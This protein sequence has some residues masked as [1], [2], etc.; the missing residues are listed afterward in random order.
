MIKL[1]CINAKGSSRLHEG[2]VYT[3]AGPIHCCNDKLIVLEEFLH[4][5]H[6]LF[7]CVVCGK[8]AR[9]VYARFQ[10]RRFIQ[11]NDPDAELGRDEVGQAKEQP[12]PLLTAPSREGIEGQSTPKAR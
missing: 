7:S 1:L 10:R 8:T 4:V 5:R 11:L 9:A 3:D 2:R 12:L 6:G